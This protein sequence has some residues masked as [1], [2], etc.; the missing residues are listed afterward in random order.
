MWAVASI[1]ETNDL[2]NNSTLR[3]KYI[4]EEKGYE[5]IR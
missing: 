3:K 4:E 1:A 2:H 5:Y